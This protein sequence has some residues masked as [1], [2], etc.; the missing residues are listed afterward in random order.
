[1][2]DDRFGVYFV[3]ITSYLNQAKVLS[4]DSS[5]SFLLIPDEVSF[6]WTEE[7]ISPL[8]PDE[9]RQMHSYDDR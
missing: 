8:Q 5:K 1:M 2:D 7:E 4:L 9:Q 3:N 6:E